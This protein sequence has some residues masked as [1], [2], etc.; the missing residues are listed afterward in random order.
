MEWEMRVLYIEGIAIHSGPESCVAVREGGGEALTGECT[1]RAIEPRNHG[2]RGADAVFMVGRQH[3]WANPNGRR[4]GPVMMTGTTR[5]TN[6]WRP[7]HGG[8]STER[9]RARGD[10][11][12]I[13]GGRVLH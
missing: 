5:A 12:R 8:C 13:G 1:G 3:R 7:K 10:S 6:R 9:A 2:N 11:C 4:N